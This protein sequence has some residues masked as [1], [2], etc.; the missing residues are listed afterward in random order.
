MFPVKFC[1]AA[2]A[3]SKPWLR[4]FSVGKISGCF[5]SVDK[6][7]L[8]AP[9]FANS[10]SGT[11]GIAAVRASGAEKRRGRNGV[12]FSRAYQ[13]APRSFLNGRKRIP[14][15]EMCNKNGPISW[16]AK[17]A[18]DGWTERA[19][20]IV[21]FQSDFGREEKKKTKTKKR[22]DSLRGVN[23]VAPLNSK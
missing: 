9:T 6:R 2:V 4:G 7:F 11:G 12:E 18:F 8:D 13:N 22:F 16:I 17:K 20:L 10:R 1:P 15:D 21:F 3:G 14:I 19:R 5:G 23:R